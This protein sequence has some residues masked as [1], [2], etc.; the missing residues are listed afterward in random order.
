[1]L[2]SQ[3]RYFALNPH[4]VNQ[5]DDAHL[6]QYYEIAAGMILFYDAL[7][8]L[9]DEVRFFMHLEVTPLIDSHF[10]DQIYLAWKE[11]AGCARRL[12]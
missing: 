4:C 2:E 10:E 1:M 12:K 9:D 7:L 5:I 3:P 6:S 11:I 8:T